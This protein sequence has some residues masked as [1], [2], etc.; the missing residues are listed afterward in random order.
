MY[1][2]HCVNY[3]NGIVDKSN[4][5][6]R[7]NV[8][9]IRTVLQTNQADLSQPKCSLLE[10]YCR[11][12]RQTYH[13]HCVNYKNGIVDKSNRT[14]IYNIFSIRMV[15]QINKTDLSQTICSLLEWNSKQIRQTY[16]IQYAIYQNGI[17]DKTNGST[18]ENEFYVRTVLQINQAD[19][20]QPK[21]SLFERYCRQIQQTYHIHRF[22]YQDGIVEKSDR[23]I[24][25]T[26]LSIRTVLQTHQTEL[27]QTMCSLSERYCRQIKQTYHGH[28]VNYY[29]GIVD[30]SNCVNY[31][32]GIIVHIDVCINLI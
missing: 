19:L 25:C 18:R 12:I 21:C 23:P 16:H 8:F 9:S 4:G 10:R 5:S 24:I 29:N 26:V 22:N 13:R 30:K 28:C 15:L 31:Q 11:Q 2:R 7:E 1:H 6:T 14:I 32:N 17:V 27:S 3:Q 20:S